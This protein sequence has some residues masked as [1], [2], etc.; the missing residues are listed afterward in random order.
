MSFDSKIEE[1]LKERGER[2]NKYGT[3][4]DFALTC[5]SIKER[6]REHPGWD[7]KPSDV[8]ES[9]DMIVHKMVRILNGDHNYPDNWDDIQGY[10]RLAS[11]TRENN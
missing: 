3:Y 4:Y 6:M 5:Q 2:Y 7:D 1:V 10:A 9:L 11:V 8:Q